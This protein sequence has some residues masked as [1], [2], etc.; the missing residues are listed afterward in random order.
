[1]IFN[2]DEIYGQDESI[3]YNTDSGLNC[4]LHV[5]KKLNNENKNNRTHHNGQ[6]SRHREFSKSQNQLIENKLKEN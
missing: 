5:V 3:D 6:Y 2:Y 1:M 4:S